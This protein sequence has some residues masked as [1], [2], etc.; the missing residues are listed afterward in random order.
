MKKIN[1]LDA[2]EDLEGKIWEAYF[3]YE[4]TKICKKIQKGTLKTICTKKRGHIPWIEMR[5]VYINWK[6]GVANAT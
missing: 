3:S 5:N 2:S 1:S 4:W 6:K